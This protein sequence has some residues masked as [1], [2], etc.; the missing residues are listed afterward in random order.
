MVSGMVLLSQTYL[1]EN[2]IISVGGEVN[3][4]VRVRPFMFSSKNVTLASA[5]LNSLSV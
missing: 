3:L 1:M 4:E 5:S 2:K